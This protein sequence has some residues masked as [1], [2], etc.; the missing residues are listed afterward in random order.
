ME[1]EKPELILIILQPMV[2][3]KGLMAPSGTQLSSGLNR[4]INKGINGTLSYLLLW[5]ISDHWDVDLWVMKAD[6]IGF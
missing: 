3:A 6:I 4:Q 2:N 1:C 5:L